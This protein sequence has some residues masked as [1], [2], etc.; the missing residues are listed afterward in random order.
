MSSVYGS[1]KAV[2]I[3]MKREYI[4]HRNIGTCMAA[5]VSSSVAGCKDVETEYCHL[6]NISLHSTYRDM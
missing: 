1:G 5:P 2:P 3:R 6:E 4:F